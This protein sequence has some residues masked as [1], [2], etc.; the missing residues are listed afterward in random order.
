MSKGLIQSAIAELGEG[1]FYDHLNQYLLW[2]DIES[3]MVFRYHFK[4]KKMSQW[5]VNHLGEY[6]SLIIP[7]SPETKNNLYSFSKPSE[8]SKYDYV[9]AFRHSLKLWDSSNN[10]A[11]VFSNLSNNEQNN[12]IRFND[13]A[14][15]SKGNLWIGTMDLK[16]RPNRGG[17]YKLNH[18]LF[19]DKYQI[20]SISNG[21][22]WSLD[23]KKMYYIDT[24]ER[25]I[26]VFIYQPEKGII[27]DTSHIIDLSNFLRSEYNVALPFVDKIRYAKLRGV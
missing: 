18:L 4:S 5:S 16:N 8:L 26:R 14:C 10:K 11:I 17:L 6:P 25:L 19:F 1:I 12:N 3:A 7:L 21:I 24:P 22:V 27:I 13:G 9:I 23:A 15:D 20:S 2:V